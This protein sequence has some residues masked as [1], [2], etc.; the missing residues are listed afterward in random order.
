M[1]VCSVSNSPLTH[2]QHQP[3]RN[4]FENKVWEVYFSKEVC[5]SSLL[6]TKFPCIVVYVLCGYTTVFQHRPKG[7]IRH[8]HGEE[9]KL[10]C[11]PS[12]CCGHHKI[13]LLFQEELLSGR[14]N[15]K[16]YLILMTPGYGGPEMRQK[17]RE[18]TE[19]IRV[20]VEFSK[21]NFGAK[22][23]SQW[24]LRSLSR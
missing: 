24:F 18:R 11:P 15:F 8:V 14:C 6:L 7:G 3:F 1:S 4:P 2:N 5:S 16:T 12:Y 20:Q 17:W 9:E 21:P 19:Y 23:W 13:I 10:S 22:N